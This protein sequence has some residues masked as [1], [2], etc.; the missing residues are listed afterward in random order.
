MTTL[1]FVRHGQSETNLSQVFTG[2]SN[3]HLTPLGWEQAERTA[4]YLKANYAVDAVYSSDLIRCLETAQPTLEA[5]GL[6]VIPEP[7]MRE[8]DVGLWEGIPYREIAERF[9]DTHRI[10]MND[11]AH[12][13]PDGGESVVDLDRR[14]SAALE[15]MIRSNPGRCIAVFSHST[16]IRLIYCRWMGLPLGDPKL[17]PPCPNASVSAAEYD[18]EGN[19]LR[20][21]CYGYDQHQ[22]DSITVIPANLI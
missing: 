15:R 20:M 3:I 11:Y 12:A 1:I 7:G 6:P 5:F 17:I 13:H 22:G 8:I 10:W 2:Q 14:V 9:P 4:A 18:D 16:P 19:F 21:I